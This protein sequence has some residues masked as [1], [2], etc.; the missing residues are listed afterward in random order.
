[1]KIV[2]IWSHPAQREVGF[3]VIAVDVVVKAFE[4]VEGGNETVVGETECDAG[5]IELVEG[6]IELS[7]E[8]IYHNNQSTGESINNRHISCFKTRYKLSAKY[9]KKRGRPLVERLPK[10]EN[11]SNQVFVS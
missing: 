6:G 9:C 5:V 10:E 2:S 3:V 11:C 8:L 7:V 4:V 1:M